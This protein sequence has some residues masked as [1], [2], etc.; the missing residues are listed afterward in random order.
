M[1]EK[2]ENNEGEWN[3]KKDTKDI[4]FHCCI[5]KYGMVKLGFVHRKIWDEDLKRKKGESVA[6]SLHVRATVIMITSR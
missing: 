5:E 1:E 6:T 3:L 2:L 4:H